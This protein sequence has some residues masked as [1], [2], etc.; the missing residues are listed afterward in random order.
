MTPAETGALRKATQRLL[1]VDSEYDQ[2]LAKLGGCPW[3][4]R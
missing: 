3:R 2:Q 4:G 1:K